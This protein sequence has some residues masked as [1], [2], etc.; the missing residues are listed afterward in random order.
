MIIELTKEE[1]DRCKEFSYESAKQQ[2]KIEF[3]Q[4]DTAP[5][6]KEEIG[7]DNLI[8]KIAEAAFAKFMLETYE[9]IVELD[10]NYYPR[11]KWDT[12][13]AI[14]NGWKIDIKATRQGG[15]WMLIEWSK[16]NFRQKDKDL[17][18][19]LIM[20]S[21]C[22]NRETDSP[23]GFV[24]LVG[25]ISLK[26]LN[27]GVKDTLV[28]RKG[29]NIPNTSTRL[30]ADNYGIHFKNLNKNWDESIRFIRENPPFSVEDYPNPYTGK[31][32]KDY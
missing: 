21:V 23:T 13:D 11:G 12:Q 9:V 27:R 6:S 18:H 8:G 14:I 22:W 15:K 24:D 10:F 32:Y 31:T 4:K 19:L 29:D 17:P 3:G 25:F 2:Q 1:L 7:R 28:L 26:A 30:Q 16:L 20:F 5:R